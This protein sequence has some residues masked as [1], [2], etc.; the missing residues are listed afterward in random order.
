MFLNEGLL[1]TRPLPPPWIASLIVVLYSASVPRTI[2]AGTNNGR[3]HDAIR[4]PLGTAAQSPR[5][6]AQLR[7]AEAP[8]RRPATVQDVLDVH[9]DT[10]HHRGWQLAHRRAAPGARLGVDKGV[11]L[12]FT[13]LISAVRDF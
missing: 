11:A 3:R 9:G 10:L 13:R 8:P 4:P 12:P 6:T 2:I 5:L 1:Y 7:A